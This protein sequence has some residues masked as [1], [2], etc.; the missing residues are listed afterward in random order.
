VATAV[1]E[2]RYA[3]SGRISVAYQ[4]VGHGPVD[5]V[6]VPGW[7]SNVE[8]AWQ[9]P[10]MAGFLRR[11]ARHGRLILFDKRG[12]GLSDPFPLDAPS[13]LEERMDDV[14]AV[15]DAAGSETAVVFGLSEGGVM[16]ALFAA[17]HPD[18]TAGLVLWGSWARQLRDADFPWG[19]T[20]EEG[21]RR[22]VRPLQQ[23]G[24]VPA[25]WFA[26]SAVGDPAFDEWFGRYQRLSSSPGMAIALLQ[27][28][29]RMDVRPVLPTIRVPTLVLHRTDDVLVSVGQGRYLADHI[30]SARLVEFPGRDHWPWFGQTEP[31][32]AEIGDF[33]GRV[34]GFEQPPVQVLATVVAGFLPR[35]VD[36]AGQVAAQ[37]GILT[38]RPPGQLLARFDGPARA[39][40]CA[41]RIVRGPAPG[42]RIG[43]H[44]GEVVFAGDR[45]D[46]IAV[47]IACEVADGAAPGEVLVTRT[48]TDLVAGSGLRFQTR[49]T[50]SLS[51]IG[52]VWELAAA[53]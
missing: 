20:R 14:R 17:T 30:P 13:S 28:N 24:S 18:R 3:R 33:L 10:H 9:E 19:W 51:A 22:F 38:A 26:P 4:V 8:L 29:A 41:L 36:V 25:H 27:A 1:P 47:D 31:I 7:I 53:L 16:S 6:V 39:V 5:V 44:T 15:M 11:L 12:T 35:D 34:A 40:E 43:I 23:R 45:L 52:S 2:V 49:G 42:G 32:L 48:V 50:Q 46:G 37:R 21:M